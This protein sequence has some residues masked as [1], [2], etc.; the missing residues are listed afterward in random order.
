MWRHLLLA[1]AAEPAPFTNQQLVGASMSAPAVARCLGMAA[2]WPACG[3]LL[4]TKP[5][6]PSPTEANSQ[7][8]LVRTQILQ[9][10]GCQ[11][12]GV[13]H[14]ITPFWGWM[15][16]C[17]ATQGAGRP[18]T[19]LAPPSSSPTAFMHLR[20]IQLTIHAMRVRFHAMHLPCRACLFHAMHSPGSQ[21]SRSTSH[22]AYRHER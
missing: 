9:L 16:P 8:Q 5:A 13:P 10:S 1:G 11:R 22:G 14:T 17:W 4:A 15:L 6:Q 20:S 3:T 18:A 2:A 21:G 12:C 7:V 19:A